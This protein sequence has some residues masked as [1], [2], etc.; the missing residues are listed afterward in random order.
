MSINQKQHGI[1]MI[2][3]LV[4][5]VILG[6]A[7]FA[8]M[9][10]QIRTLINTSDAVHRAQAVRLIEDFSERMKSTLKNSRLNTPDYA[11]YTTAGFLAGTDLGTTLAQSMSTCDS[12]CSD[13]QIAQMDRND[14]ILKVSQSLPG[15]QTALFVSTDRQQLGVMVGW[16]PNERQENVDSADFSTPFAVPG[17]LLPAGQANCPAGL[18][19]HLMYIQP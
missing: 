6:L 12:S 9:N 13:A 5:I 11:N 18:R 2:E 10:L 19:C 4:S 14:L 15:G 16:L 17:T 1:S 7:I 8:M 3:A